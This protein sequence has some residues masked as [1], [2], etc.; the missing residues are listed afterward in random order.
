MSDTLFVPKDNF[1]WSICLTKVGFKM[2]FFQLFQDL[3]QSFL[4]EIL[5]FFLTFPFNPFLI[6]IYLV[7]SR[8]CI[9]LHLTFFFFFTSGNNNVLFSVFL[10]FYTRDNLNDGSYGDISY[11][12]VGFCK[13]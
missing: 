12:L 7:K 10:N 8:K 6:Y 5:M 13:L 9:H 11:S 3:H 4:S 2:S 1:V